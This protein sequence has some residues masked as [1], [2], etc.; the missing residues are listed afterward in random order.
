MDALRIRDDFPILRR[1]VHG[2]PLI[3]LDSAATSQKPEVVIDAESDFY[4]LHNAAAH[5]GSHALA[6]EATACYEGARQRIADFVGAPAFELVFTRSATDSIN[7]IAHGFLAA[8]DHARQGR[9]ADRRFVLNPGDSIVITEM[10]HHANLVP[11]Q[12]L[13]AKTGATLRWVSVDPSGRL[14]TEELDELVDAST[15]LVSWTHASNVLGHVVDP[16]PF[17]QAAAKSGAVTILDACQSIPHMPVTLPSLGVD[18]AVWSAHKMLGPTG[19]GFLWGRSE[20]LNALPAVDTG[21]SMIGKVTMQGSTYL[22]APARFE[23]GVPPMAQAVAAA[24]AVEYLSSVGMSEVFAHV[25]ALASDAAQRL[26]A[27]DGVSVLGSPEDAPAIGVSFTVDGIHPHDVGQLLDADGIAV[28]VG[29]HCAWPLM[30]A[31]GVPATVRASFSV[32]STA[33]EVAALVDSVMRCQEF[34]RLRTAGNGSSRT[35]GQVTSQVT[36]QVTGT[37]AT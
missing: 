8:T 13:C 33:D 1:T 2:K 32:Y 29:H 16:R 34:F 9:S 3:Y 5:R 30:Q 19:I 20:L 18:F 4:R 27:I 36:S 21:G 15:R 7:L 28:R 12:E 26:H 17:V 35:T 14:R 11:W 10:E 23:P 24:A 22:D 31:L 6:E 37:V 25:S